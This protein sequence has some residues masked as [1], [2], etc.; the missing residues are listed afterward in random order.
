MGVGGEIVGVEVT[1]IV[2]S[3]GGRE[4]VGINTGVV[5]TVVGRSVGFEVDVPEAE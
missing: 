5:A 1:G 2:V 3:G 4:A